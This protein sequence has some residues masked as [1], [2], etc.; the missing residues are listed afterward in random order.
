MTGGAARFL[1]SQE[2]RGALARALTPALPR[3][4]GRGPI[5]PL[6]SSGISPSGG[7]Q[8]LACARL[9]R[10]EARR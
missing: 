10:R 5:R 6:C 3:L 7:E 4:R 9:D 1:L 2:R 8:L